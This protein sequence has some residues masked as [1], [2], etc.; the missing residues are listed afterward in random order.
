M[1]GEHHGWRGHG[2]HGPDC[3]CGC[4][5]HG[6]GEQRMEH[7]AH[8]HA[9][10]HPLGLKRHFLSEGERGAALEQYLKDLEGEA[11]G[12]RE[13]LAELRGTSEEAK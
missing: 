8:A 2:G 13:R 3:G 4:H 5:G 10:E 12:V 7:G 1:C 9:G 6:H 11:Q